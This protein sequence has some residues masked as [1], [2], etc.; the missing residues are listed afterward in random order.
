MPI[1][2]LMKSVQRHEPTSVS[3]PP[4]SSPIDAPP[5]ETA[6]KSA[7]ARL[8][9]ASSGALVVSRARTLGAAIA[10][11]TPWTARAATSWPGVWASPP[12]I[13]ARVKRVRPISKSRSRPRT[14]PRR[15]PRSSRPPKA[16]V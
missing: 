7:K 8:R 15:P 3:R 5:D 1:G 11:P 13:E 14:S 12:T 6:A 9:A 4:S 10:A 16:R 2:T